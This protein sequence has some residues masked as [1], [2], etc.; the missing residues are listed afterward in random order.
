[1]S[2]KNT[3]NGRSGYT[4]NALVHSRWSNHIHPCEDSKCDY[5]GP[6]DAFSMGHCYDPCPRCGSQKTRRTGRFI[7]ELRPRRLIPWT[8]K[9]VFIGVD[10]KE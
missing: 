3:E 9:K 7:Y 6:L 2:D 10:W 1:M 8:N 5:I 4:A